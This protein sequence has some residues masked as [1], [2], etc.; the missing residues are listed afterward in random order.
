MI[1]ST[2]TIQQD[3]DA[4]YDYLVTTTNDKEQEEV[5]MT[6]EKKVYQ[7]KAE[8]QLE[9]WK[10]DIAKLKAK[11]EVAGA[12]A[13]QELNNVVADLQQKKEEATQQLAELRNASES[14]WEEVK[15][16]FEISWDALGMAVDDAVAKFDKSKN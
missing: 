14:A 16:G 13:Q 9:V 8:A 7:K 3:N 4:K 11:A 5:I 1:L 6:D 10:A 2:P 12:D 15:A